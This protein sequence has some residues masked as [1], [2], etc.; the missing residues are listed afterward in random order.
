MAG[1]ESERLEESETVMV[2]IPSAISS[3]HRIDFKLIRT[4]RCARHGFR[5]LK[6][7][8]NKK[9]RHSL[10]IFSIFVLFA[11][12]LTGCRRCEPEQEHEPIERERNCQQ[13]YSSLSSRRFCDIDN[14]LNTTNEFLSYFESK[15]ECADCC[16]DA[17]QIKKEFTDIKDLF[18]Y[19]D[20]LEPSSRLCAYYQKV[21]QNRNK[22]SSSSYETV[23]ETWDCIVN[24]K[25][26]TYLNDGLN[27]IKSSDFARYLID[28]AEELAEEWYGGG[29]P[30]GWVVKDSYIL[31][32]EISDPQPVEGKAARRCSCTV[33]VSMEGAVFSLRSGGVEI[34]VEGTLGFSADNKCTLFFSKGKNTVLNVYGGLA[35]RSSLF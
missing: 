12:T 6:M 2:W 14:A 4:K 35:R 22:F 5:E 9:N 34:E 31:N 24:E 7:E 29:G 21:E 32:N 8:K 19:I 33:H 15:G 20:N 18:S 28:Y 3:S 16:Y 1:L 25:E 23:R 17:R 26:S 13:E 30:F 11:V 27:S 10:R